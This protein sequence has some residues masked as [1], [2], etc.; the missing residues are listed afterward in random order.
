MTKEKMD[1]Y[2]IKE[3]KEGYIVEVIEH[4]DHNRVYLVDYNPESKKW[5]V[6]IFATPELA[7]EAQQRYYDA[8]RD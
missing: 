3:C 5:E 7:Q 8:W 4:F 6:C 2:G 1:F